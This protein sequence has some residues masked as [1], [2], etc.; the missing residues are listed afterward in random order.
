M[1]ELSSATCPAKP[2]WHESV[3]SQSDVRKYSKGGKK[4]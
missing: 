4:A 1:Y 3:V 2:L